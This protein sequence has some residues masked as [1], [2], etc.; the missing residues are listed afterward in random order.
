M[1]PLKPANKKAT[2]APTS[3]SKPSVEVPQT[4][5]LAVAS[6][7]A[8]LLA[9]L[10]W[11]TTE[12][13]Q[14]AAVRKLAETIGASNVKIDVKTNS[15]GRHY[16]VANQN[17]NPSTPVISL[18]QASIVDFQTI[19]DQPA[20]V[21]IKRDNATAVNRIA[22]EKGVS[23]GGFNVLSFAT[24]FALEK[25]RGSASRLADFFALLSEDQLRF[26]TVFWPEEVLPCLD[27]ALKSERDQLLKVIEAGVELAKEVCDTEEG[28]A[29]GCKGRPLTEEELRWAVAV[30]LQHN[31][32]DQAFVP[33]VSFARFDNTKAASVQPQFDRENSVLHFVN[34]APIARG[35]EI[36]LNHM[37]GPNVLLSAFGAFDESQSRGV[38]LPLQLPEDE[39]VRRVCQIGDLQFGSNGKPRDTLVNCLTLLIAPDN[40]RAKVSKNPRKYR[41]G[42]L[43]AY[44]FGNLTIGAA[45]LSEDHV[46][47]A[48]CQAVPATPLANAIRTYIS[49]RRQ[50][51]DANRQYLEQQM[52]E[53]YEQAGLPLPTPP[54]AA[55]G[56]ENVAASAEATDTQL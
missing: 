4:A 11:A 33:I 53:K 29:A 48:A 43:A 41:T 51:M 39:T 36:T 44:V 37:R 10:W 16:L 31:F 32:Q 49:W 15:E 18:S 22:Q 5:K 35:S 54:S 2:A 7:F 56:E 1:A 12:G 47:D 26:S 6:F 17:L 30:Y 21:M 40:Q 14:H 25:R 13:S 8:A 45:R 34:S 50:V 19:G 52:V 38:E 27:V 42:D 46:D 20:G 28:E 9:V 3:A 55:E 24:Y 23:Q